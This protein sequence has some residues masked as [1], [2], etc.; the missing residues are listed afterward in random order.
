MYVATVLLSSAVAA[1][2]DLFEPAASLSRLHGTLQGEA[3]TVRQGGL[4]F[5]VTGAW[6][7]DPVLQGDASAVSRLLPVHLQ[8]SWAPAKR[9]RLD[10]GLPTYANADV[11]FTDFSGPALG[12]A[13]VGALWSIAGEDG[14]PLAL[15]FLPRFHIGTG[16]AN[17][18]VRGGF[19]GSATVALGGTAG[20]F[21]W[22]AN[23]GVRI[24]ETS[25]LQGE[26]GGVGLA[27][28]TVAGG[29]IRL[30]DRVR[31]GADLDAQ[32]GA[33]ANDA[34]DGQTN[35]NVQGFGQWSN[36]QGLGLIAGVG[37]GLVRD[38]GTA[39]FRL[40]AGVSWTAWRSDGDGD[41]VMDRLD[42]CPE[43]REDF[44]S[45]EDGDGCPD[46]D[47]DG[48]AL[49]DTKDACPDEAEDR[50]SFEDDDGCPE[51]DNDADGLLD[52]EDECPVLAGL[53]VH[54]GCP[55]TDEDGLRDL[56]DQCPESAGPTD[57]DGCPDSDDDGLHD[58]I[59]Q[60]PE[61][62]RAAD[63]MLETS[64]GCPRKVY[65]ADSGLRLDNRIPFPEGTSQLT[66]SSRQML[67]EVATVLIANPG[68]GRV[69]VQGHTDNV[70]PRTYNLRLSQKRANA[71]VAYLVA[72]GVPSERLVAK[73][74]GESKPRFT[75]RTAGGRTR[76]RRVQFV[77][78][79]PVPRPSDPTDGAAEP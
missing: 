43:A 46:P 23:G 20:I 9:I 34:R 36:A 1:D 39:R 45:F 75:N 54:R 67:N 27:A 2:V 16:N 59:D 8:G 12:D 5:G 25:P 51:P 48:D 73:G 56:D 4:A 33:V 64:D 41:T 77:F 19:A 55:D 32:F 71:V 70:G 26:A 74:Y 15:G 7:A 11:P 29:A 69:E 57:W 28:R 79:E 44:D 17:A 18:L 30:H 66:N 31:V 49:V 68:V 52:G 58:G 65:V 38:A 50:D 62:P 53:D 14:G 47:N 24:A 3:P 61:E 60:C 40:F 37:T 35:V 6:I 13:T 76:N 72:Q 22:V 10:L 21:S 78:L 63:E 42:A